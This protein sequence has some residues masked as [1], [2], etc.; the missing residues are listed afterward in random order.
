MGPNDI[1]DTGMILSVI[2]LCVESVCSKKLAKPSNIDYADVA[3]RKIKCVIFC[4]L[5]SSISQSDFPTSIEPLVSIVR[6]PVV[7]RS[8]VS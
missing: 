1:T 4:Q 5:A 2:V 6:L 7:G 3:V 8:D